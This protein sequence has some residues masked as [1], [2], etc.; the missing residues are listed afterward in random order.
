MRR[1]IG[2]FFFLS[3]RE[4]FSLR[5]IW[6]MQWMEPAAAADANKEQQGN[7]KI[8]PFAKRSAM[9][10]TAAGGANRKQQK[11]IFSSPTRLTMEKQLAAAATADGLSPSQRQK[12]MEI[13]AL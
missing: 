6:K 9:E 3:E 10:L 7:K 2:V 11:K 1:G 12:W 5:L 8:S 13:A 4:D